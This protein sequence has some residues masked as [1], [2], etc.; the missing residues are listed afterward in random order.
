VLWLTIKRAAI[1][2]VEAKFACDNDFAAERRERLSDK[3]LVCIWAVNFGCIEERDALFT[4]FTN[5]L[6]ALMFVSGRSVVGTRYSC[7]Q[8]P[9]LILP[10]FRVFVFSFRSPAIAPFFALVVD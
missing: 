9:F 8:I 5:D 3:L 6:N 10:M 7:S 4:S 1:L 2:V